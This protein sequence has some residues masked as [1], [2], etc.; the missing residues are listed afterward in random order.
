M[1]RNR[2]DAALKTPGS[3]RPGMRDLQRISLALTTTVALVQPAFA[4]EMSHGEM[5]AAIRSADYPC[6]HV[7]QLQASGDNSWYVQC[8][9]GMYKVTRDANGQFS[10]V[11][12]N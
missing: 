11:K 2:Y 1:L 9:S 10:V 4:A 6:R 7:L 8:N 5:A 3:R 12:S